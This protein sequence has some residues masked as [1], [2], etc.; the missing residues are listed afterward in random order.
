MADSIR[1]QQWFL[2]S[3]NVGRAQAISNGAG[4]TVA[5]VDTGVYPHRDFK[6]NLLAGYNL[7]TAKPDGRIDTDGHGTN[8][9]GLIA[10]SGHGNSGVLG[11]ALRAKILPIKAGNDGHIPGGMVAKGI[12]YAVAHKAQVINVSIASAPAFELLKAIKDANKADVV[13]VAGSGN[14]GDQLVGYPAA[15]DGVLAVGA[16]DKKGKHWSDSTHGPNL[17]ICA[18]GVDIV[19]TGIGNKYVGS[20]GT[21]DATAIV[22][23]AVAMVRARFPK[24]SAP[25]VIHR[26]TATADDI[27]PPGRDDD[28]GFGELNIVKALTADVPPLS[29]GAPSAST[30]PSVT[31]TASATASSDNAAEPPSAEKADGGAPLIVGALVAVL[32]VAGLVGFLAVRRRRRA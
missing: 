10:G 1:D 9:A 13:I 30:S 2:R 5:L 22:S 20:D 25:E 27:G 7:V 28:C 29:G 3:L 23:G 11:I 32:L 31:T 26:I 18:P 17:Q 16:T 15:A 21:S 8:M 14:E 19:S 12:D 6:G 24:L 4:I